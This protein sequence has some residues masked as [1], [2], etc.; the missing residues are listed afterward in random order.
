MS[1]HMLQ[2]GLFQRLI[3]QARRLIGLALLHRDP[4]QPRP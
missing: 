2:E 4:G 1:W 3:G